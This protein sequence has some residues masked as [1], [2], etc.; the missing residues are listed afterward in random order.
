MRFVEL[1]VVFLYKFFNFFIGGRV[2]S[3]VILVVKVIRMV[4]EKGIILGFL[5]DFYDNKS[6]GKF[7]SGN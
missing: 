5:V 1:I 2:V 6:I 7:V 3:G 4:V